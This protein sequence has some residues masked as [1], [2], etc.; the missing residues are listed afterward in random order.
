MAVKM[1]FMVFWVMMP[2]DLVVTII[3]EEHITSIFRV[4]ICMTTQH[5]HFEDEDDTFL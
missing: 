3:L 5:L 4:A 1:S 2:C